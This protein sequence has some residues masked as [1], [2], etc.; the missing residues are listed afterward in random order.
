MMSYVHPDPVSFWLDI[1]VEFL[2]THWLKAN[3][4][5]CIGDLSFV[6]R[7]S[8]FGREGRLPNGENNDQ[9]DSN[10]WATWKV[11]HYRVRQTQHSPS[12]SILVIPQTLSE[13]TN[14]TKMGNISSP[15]LKNSIENHLAHNFL[16]CPSFISWLNH[17]ILNCNNT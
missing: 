10:V 1:P 14:D 15:L 11:A 3:E 6:S 4:E 9:L 12:N 8:A 13:T 16:S 5:S 17:N 7:V 2:M